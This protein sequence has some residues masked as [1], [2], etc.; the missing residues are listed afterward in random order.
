[1][2]AIWSSK[3]GG[4]IAVVGLFSLSR[5]RVDNVPPML[6]PIYYI[7]G[8]GIGISLFVLFSILRLTIRVEISEKQKRKPGNSYIF[9]HWHGQ[10]PLS[11]QCGIPK[12]FSL[13]GEGVHVWMQHPSWYM[14]PIHVLIR[15][16]G[17]ARIILGSTG[18]SGREGA[19]QLVEYLR[20][21][22]STVLLPDGPHGPPFILKRGI[23]HISL[24]SQVPILP[25]QF[26]ASRFLESSTWDRK[27]WPTPFSVIR[28]QFGNPLQVTKDNFD[29]MYGEITKALG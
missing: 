16:M 1:L 12:I 6:K 7:Y 4:K 26:R 3:I 13:L 20:K 14:K 17:V 29:E 28:V 18:H 24:Q 19:D 5:Y 21:G 10:V 11:L 25:M 15:L 27:Q 22:Y 23:L 8:Y 2:L 9:C